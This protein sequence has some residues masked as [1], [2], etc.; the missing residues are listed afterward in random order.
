MKNARGIG[1]KIIDEMQV[2][3]TDATMVAQKMIKQNDL[4]STLQYASN[5][6]GV[7]L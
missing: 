5:S 4:H 7:L 2:Q 1:T 3:N 6:F